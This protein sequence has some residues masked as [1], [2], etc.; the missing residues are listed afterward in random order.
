VL[1]IQR[2]GQQQQSGVS[3][4]SI[5]QPRVVVDVTYLG[6]AILNSF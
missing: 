6:Y 5:N 2:L 1:L 3:A 4:A